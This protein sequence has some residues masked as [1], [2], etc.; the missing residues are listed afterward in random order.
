MA[1]TKDTFVQKLRNV[2]SDVTLAG[3]FCGVKTKTDFKFKC[4]HVNSTTPDRMLQGA[5]CLQCA[6]KQ[7][8]ALDTKEVLARL[9]QFNVTTDKPVAAMTDRR[10]FTCNVCQHQWTTTVRLLTGTKYGCPVC[11]KHKTGYTRKKVRIQGTRFSLQGYEPRAIKWL[12][13]NTS[14]RSNEIKTGIQVPRFRYKER[15]VERMYLPDLYVER[16]NRIIEVKSVYTA[17]GRREWFDNLKRKRQAVVATGT[18]FS[19]LLFDRVGKNGARKIALPKNWHTLTY[20]EFK[21]LCAQ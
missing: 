12:T 19:L 8:A 10:K 21:N 5:G 7:R 3:Q 18:Q 1:Y 9:A 4:G 14:I 6:S 15:G 16:F 20:T 17:A 11:A 2:R 13:A